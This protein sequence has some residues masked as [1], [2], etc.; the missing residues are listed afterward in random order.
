MVVQWRGAMTTGSPILDNDHQILIG[1]LN[2]VEKAIDTQTLEGVGS[3][4]EDVLQ[5]TVDHFEREELI[6]AQIHYS[7]AKNHKKL[8]A[9]LRNQILHLN[10]KFKSTTDQVQKKELATELHSFLNDWLVKHI[11][12]ED[13]KIRPLVDKR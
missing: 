1:L 9:D 5:Y 2:N 13:I 10:E 6:Q 4:L 3:A 12:H 8:H 7:D 11:M